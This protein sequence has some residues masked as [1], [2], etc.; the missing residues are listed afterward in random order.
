MDDLNEDI[1]TLKEML[2]SLQ[3]EAYGAQTVVSNFTR[4]LGSLRGR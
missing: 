1:G 3:T 4:E 2:E